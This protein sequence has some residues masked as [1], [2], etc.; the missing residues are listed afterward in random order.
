MKKL[1]VSTSIIAALGLT[2]CG[3]ETIEDLREEALIQTPVS[4]I[5][6]DPANGNLNIPNDLLLLPS[7][8]GFFD[9]TL[10]IPVD[11]P[12]DFSDPQNALNILDGWSTNTPFVI[13]VDTATGVSLDA[14]TLSAG[15]RIFEATLGLNRN[16]PDCAQITIPSAGCKIGDELSFGVDFV[17]SLA[18]ENTITV[19]PLIPLKE[20]QGYV[21]VMT[22]DLKDS[23]GAAV[24]GSTTW[25]LVK[26]D[27]NTAPLASESQLSLQGLINSHIDVLQR[28][29]LSRDEISYVSAFTTLSV[30]PV[31]AAVKQLYV[32]EFAQRS[33]LGDPTAGQALPAIIIDSAG[34][35]ANAMEA[36]GAVTQQAVDG[37]VALALSNPAASALSP[38][39]DAADFSALTTCDGLLAAAGGVFGPATGQS[40]A[41]FD[42]EVN[43][44][45]QQI[46][47]GILGQGAGPLCAASLY[48]GNV[49]LPYYSAIPRA[50]NPAAP[51]NEFWEAACDS[52]IVLAGAGDA[53]AAAVPGPN[54]ALCSAVGLRDLTINGQKV[55]PA[56]NLT[57][58]N[59]VPL[60]KGSNE[61]RE[62][63]D[64]QLSIP[65]PAVAGALG[66]N[67]SM[68]EGGWPVVMLVHGIT[69]K[70]E[71]MLSIS[72]A[73][74][75]AGFA[76]VA[77]DQPLHGSRGFDVDPTNPGDEINATTVSATA[78]LNLASLPTARDNSRQAVSDL[79]G[80]RLALNAFVNATGDTAVNVNGTDVSLMGVSLGAIT[81]GMFASIANTPFDGELAPLSGLF[82]TPAVS[83][84]SPGGGLAQFL[85]ESPS[86]GPLIQ[87]FLLSVASSDF[88]TFLFSRFATADLSEAQLVEGVVGYLAQATEAQ[89]AEANG[90][91]AQ[92][93]FAAQSMTDQ[94]DP[95]N[96]F[97]T[98][99]QN[100]NVH[101]ITVV[102]DGADNLP[103]QVIPVSTSIP[104]S[105]QLPLVNLMGL[106]TVS[107]T[108]SLS[109]A[110][111]GVVLYTAGAHASSI[112]PVP[113]P[114]VTVE[115]QTQVAT[116]LA[117]DG[118]VIQ[119]ENE[120]I[121]SN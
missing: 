108:V 19:V 30:T 103:D 105:G 100:T 81:G 113:D 50:E 112:N 49:T 40:F 92:F 106:D 66:I 87:G 109:E 73:L 90:I 25:D 116:Y 102:G 22:T 1:L 110:I 101:M 63:I 75:L 34:T 83:L 56:R 95:I 61:G 119:I 13:D 85:I 12:S 35:Q 88:Q 9:G 89:I 21:L 5:V 99:S 74:S 57:K 82:A 7:D 32:G 79:L 26:Q 53:L 47:T 36:L 59:P 64:V 78:F 6:F 111:S 77:I 44:V 11:D 18:D 107:S 3:G 52:G 41:P 96:Y 8:D 37:A 39:F 10:N 48:Q 91:F 120:A 71:D 58:F 104:L 45:V 4:R 84:E 38:L 33:A 98:L 70:K 62:T 2:G 72:G 55:D 93:S 17:L 117:T 94:A 97:A 114:A 54:D 15:V 51:T 42:T 23:S 14:S 121:V 68:P 115:M 60:M 28:V 31:M 118:R 69:S 86:F 16:D 80:L 27:I 24:R 46:G 20:A 76:T 43:A 29:G 65:N 67:I